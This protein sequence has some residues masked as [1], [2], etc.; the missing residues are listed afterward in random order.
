MNILATR[1]TKEDIKKLK[2]IYKQPLYSPLELTLQLLSILFFHAI[3]DTLGF[4][5]GKWEFNYGIKK[6]TPEFTNELIYD[7]FHLGGVR[8]IDIKGW[9]VSDD[10]IL[11]LST[12]NAFIQPYKTL[13]DLGNNIRTEYIKAIPRL[14]GRYPGTKTWES[15]KMLERGVEWSKVP[16]DSNAIGAGAAMRTTCIGIIYPGKLLRK[17]LIITSIETSRITHNSATGFLGGLTSALFTAY[18]IEKIPIARWPIK[19]IKLLKSKKIDKYLQKSRPNEYTKYLND[20]YTF[21]GKWEKYVS[22][23]YRNNIPIIDDIKIFINPVQ[24]IKYLADNFSNTIGNDFFPGN[25]G[26]DATIIAFDSLLQSKG[27]WE[28]LILYSILHPGDS[29]TVGAIASSWY[30]AFYNPLYPLSNCECGKF[31]DEFYID[32]LEVL[33]EIME[34]FYNFFGSKKFLRI[35]NIFRNRKP[36]TKTKV[37]INEIKEIDIRMNKYMDHL[38]DNR[39]DH[40][41]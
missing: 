7:F 6:P 41:I 16:Y 24:R 9:K 17:K 13:N 4:R 35:L 32:D 19:L 25:C 20:S 33:E 15:L 39:L 5:N 11:N 30:A 26:D 28:K 29:D 8:G 36:K 21:I 38:I 3:G 1:H 14:E 27:N 31:I 40:S 2:E 12:F 10:T 37:V 34:L 18:G 23:R 22:I